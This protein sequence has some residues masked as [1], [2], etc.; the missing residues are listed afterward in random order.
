MKK[1][2]L[3]LAGCL[4]LGLLGGCGSGEMETSE[5]ATEPTSAPGTTVAFDKGEAPNPILTIEMEDSTLGGGVIKA[6][7]YPD[8]APQAVF[9]MIALANSGFYDGVGFHRGIPGF[10]AQG[11]DPDG[12]G[13]GGPGY[14]IKGEF[15]SNGVSNSLKHTRGVLSM[16][17]KSVPNDSA[18]SQFFLMVAD[19]PHL[20]G[21]YA[22]F[23]KVIEGI[24]VADA[25]VQLPKQA[26]NSELLQNQPKMKTVRV[27]TFGV[28]YPEP[29]KLPDR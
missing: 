27:E 13:G 9:N 11:G 18:G 29:E 4:L 16:A 17:R 28:T 24:E 26:A 7:L 23:G 12:T 6:E 25:I 10:M 14:C 19:A 5:N 8:I 20:N 15:A 22:A 1:L 21:G 2:A 3:V